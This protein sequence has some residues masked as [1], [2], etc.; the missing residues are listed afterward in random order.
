M[1]QKRSGLDKKV[2]NSILLSMNKVITE[3]CIN[4]NCVVLEGLGQFIPK[5]RK[6][7]THYDAATKETLLYPPKI[8]VKFSVD[9][10]IIS[11]INT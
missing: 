6:E 5:K 10:K 7:F 3:Q 9:K 1:L 2:I 4:L 11:K 8:S